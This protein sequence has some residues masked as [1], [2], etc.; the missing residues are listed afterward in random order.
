MPAIE[1]KDTEEVKRC[2]R[3]CSG[4]DSDCDS[5]TYRTPEKGS[6]TCTELL[7]RDALHSI[8][9]YERKIVDMTNEHTDKLMKI[10]SKVTK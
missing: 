9:Q 5:C 1:H 10:L 6:S 7:M 8:N 3:I 2:L 4:K